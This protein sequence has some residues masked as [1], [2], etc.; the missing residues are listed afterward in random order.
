MGLGSQCGFT[1]LGLALG[2]GCTIQGFYCSVTYCRFP[3]ICKTTS[4][5]NLL[6]CSSSSLPTVS[7]SLLSS[8]LLSLFIRNRTFLPELGPPD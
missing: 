5:I 6:A 3:F 4:S 2:V 8:S 1:C 7:V